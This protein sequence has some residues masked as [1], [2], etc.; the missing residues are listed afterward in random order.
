[1]TMTSDEPETLPGMNRALRDNIDKLSARSRDETANA[2]LSHRVALRIT[3]FAGSMLFVAIHLLLFGGWIAANTVRV[4]G[5]PPFDPS[6]VILAMT[7]SV[8]A[9]FLSTFVLISQNRMAEAAKRS[10]DLDLHISL[11]TE[12]EL[13]RLATLMQRIAGR[14]DVSVDDLGLG[15]IE[16]D[17]EPAKVLDALQ[18]QESPKSPD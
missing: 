12:H 4:P 14:L 5:I 17:I 7:A 13:T 9:I 11:L 2:P 8:E 1:M 16:A 6:L 15:E 10:A 3:R 18:R